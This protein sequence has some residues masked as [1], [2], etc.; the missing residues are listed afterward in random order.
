MQ[1]T[2]GKFLKGLFY[3]EKSSIPNVGT[4]DFLFITFLG[5][6]YAHFKL[7]MLKYNAE[8]EVTIK[9][10]VHNVKILFHIFSLC[11]YSVE[12]GFY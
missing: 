6:D 5:L 10:F 4:L 3:K 9:C 8:H 1:S 2:S 11:R 12:S 7:W